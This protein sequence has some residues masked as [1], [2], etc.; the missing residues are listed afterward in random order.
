MSVSGDRAPIRRPA[1]IVAWLALLA[2]PPAMV[3]GHVGAPGLDWTRNFVSTFAARAPHDDWVTAAML[4]SASGMGC[5]GLIAAGGGG[6]FGRVAGPLVALLMGAAASGLLVLAAF[7]EA[8]PSLA[9]LRNLG[10]AAARQQGFHDAGLLVFF[11]ATVLALLVAGGAMAVRP[12]GGAARLS[13]VLV[14]ASGPLSFA[15]MTTPWLGAVGLPADAAGLKQ[16]AAFLVLWIGGVALLAVLSRLR[17]TD[18][19]V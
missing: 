3:A 14:A 4:L 2:A 17:R 8:A 10:Y 9:A 1:H 16:R 5:I 13:G 19:S 12:P 6:V 18:P 15:A 7:E 11:Y